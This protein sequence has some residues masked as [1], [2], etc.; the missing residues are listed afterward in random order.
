MSGF[1]AGDEHARD[2]HAPAQ[3]HPQRRP[4]DVQAAQ[5]HALLGHVVFHTGSD[6]TGGGRGREPRVVAHVALGGR[7]SQAVYP[8]RLPVS[9]VL[10]CSTDEHLCDI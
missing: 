7:S 10:D 5:L 8:L 6:V 4:V 3:I 2:V 1:L 9:H